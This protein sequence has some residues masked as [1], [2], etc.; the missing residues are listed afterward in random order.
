MKAKYTLPDRKTLNKL[1]DEAANLH[2]AELA[3][4]RAAWFDMIYMVIVALLIAV[5]INMFF[6]QIIRVQGD[7]MLPTFHTK[8]RVIAEKISYLFRDPK[9]TEVIICKYYKGED[10]VIKRV[11]GVPG[12]TIEIIEGAIYVNGEQLDESNYW[13]DTIWRPSTDMPPVLVPEK[14]VFVVG[15]NR[16]DSYDSRDVGPVPYDQIVGHVALIVWPINSI[17]GF[18]K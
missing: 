7:S 13:N 10:N 16:N 14:H 6:F 5:S 15:D 12:D 3:F 1:R 2:E 8:E 17:G 9:R 4:K 11:I 18:A